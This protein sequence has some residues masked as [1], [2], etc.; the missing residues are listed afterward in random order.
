MSIIS[1][2][3]GTVHVCFTKIKMPHSVGFDVMI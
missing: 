2:Q 3:L 1:E